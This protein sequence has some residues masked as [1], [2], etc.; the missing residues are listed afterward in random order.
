[1]FMM[2]GCVGNIPKESEVTKQ[3]LEAVVSLGDDCHPQLRHTAVRLAGHLVNWI[4]DNPQYIAA[5]FQFLITTMQVRVGYSA[6]PAA[7]AP[8]TRVAAIICCCSADSKQQPGC[9]R[10]RV[11]WKNQ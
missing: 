10:Y 8:A 9:I 7:L 2:M 5:V 11:C 3:L 4:S 1:M 6:R